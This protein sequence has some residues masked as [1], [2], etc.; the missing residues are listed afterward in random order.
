MYPKY[1]YTIVHPQYP[2]TTIYPQYMRPISYHILLGD[3]FGAGEM[4]LKVALSSAD[5]D[6]GKWTHRQ[7]CW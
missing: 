3:G 4:A 7:I 2:Y 6:I 1:P 5:V